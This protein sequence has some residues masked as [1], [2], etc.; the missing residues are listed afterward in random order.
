MNIVA[1][2]TCTVDILFSNKSLAYRISACEA[3]A[4]MF[5]NIYNNGNKNFNLPPLFNF[6]KKQVPTRG[7]MYKYNVK[8]FNTVAPG[9]WPADFTR[10]LP[11]IYP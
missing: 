10:E 5:N 11:A 1:S 7:T 6:L 8:S 9:K 3:G 4:E 2:H